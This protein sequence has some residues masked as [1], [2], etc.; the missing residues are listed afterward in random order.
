MHSNSPG[1]L[2]LYHEKIGTFIF[3]LL[4]VFLMDSLS[5]T[6]QWLWL[7]QDNVT[8]YSFMSSCFSQSKVLFAFPHLGS[9]LDPTNMLHFSICDVEAPL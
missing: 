2:S 3:L 9:L 8:T 1:F 7:T 5:Q 6:V 4:S